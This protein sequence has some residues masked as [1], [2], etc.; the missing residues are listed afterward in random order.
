[1]TEQTITMST[2]ELR[3]LE[4]IQSLEAKHIRQKQAAEQLSLSVRQVRG[5]YYRP[6][7]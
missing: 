1:M 3:R 6:I 5:V 4:V 7:G 2:K